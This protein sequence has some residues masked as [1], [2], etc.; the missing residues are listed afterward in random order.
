M[1]YYTAAI[2]MREREHIPRVGPSVDR[3]TIEHVRETYNSVSIHSRVCLICAQVRTD[4]HG[5]NSDIEMRRIECITGAFRERLDGE[6]HGGIS[7][8]SFR[9]N[10]CRESFIERFSNRKSP[11]FNKLFRESGRRSW[12]WRRTILFPD[13]RRVDAFCCPEDVE[14]CD[15]RHDEPEDL[16]LTDDDADLVAPT[17]AVAGEAGDETKQAASG[18]SFRAKSKLP[19]RASKN[20]HKY[21]LCSE[22]SAPICRECFARMRKKIRLGIPLALCNDNAIGYCCKLIVEQRARWIEVA[23]ASPAW[24]SIICYYI[25]DHRGHLGS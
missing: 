22:C 14:L 1:D 5:P 3:R 11:L 8:D 24:T 16:P 20:H 15:G 25:E 4:T 18:R 7:P 19:A 6:I 12:E 23:A 21:E 13:G 10:L 9:L 17:S 2:A